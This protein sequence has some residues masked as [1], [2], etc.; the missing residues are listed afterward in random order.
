MR[1]AKLKQILP[2]LA[3]M[4]LALIPLR[5]LLW[6]DDWMTHDHQQYAVRLAAL[7]AAMDEGQFLGRWVSVLK[8]GWGYPLF[9]YYPPGF[10]LL[11]A[12]PY[13]AGLDLM[14]SIHLTLALLQMIG[15]AG[16]YG[17]GR[18]FMGRRAAMICA[19][20]WAFLPYQQVN[21]FVRGAMA[22]FA[23]LQ[24]LAAALFLQLRFI[25]KP[26]AANGAIAAAAISVMIITH[27][28]TA[29][30]GTAVLAAMGT[31]YSQRQQRRDWRKNLLLA[32]LPLIAGVGL[33][34]FYWLPALAE[35]HFVQTANMLGGYYD[36]RQH[37]LQW[38]Q[39]LNVFHWG[40]GASTAEPG[41]G[42]PRH[43][44]LAPLALVGLG[45]W[46]VAMR[47]RKAPAVLIAASL[48]ALCLLLLTLEASK[49]IWA[50]VPLMPYI[51]FP[52]RLLGEVGVLMALAGGAGAQMLFDAVA[53]H[54]RAWA[55]A[56][57]MGFVVLAPPWHWEPVKV[58]KPVLSGHPSAEMLRSRDWAV[59]G[60]DEFLPRDAAA[61]ASFPEIARKA[62]L[63]STGTARVVRSGGTARIHGG[64]SES[65]AI[66]LGEYW[67]PSVRVETSDASMSSRPDPMGLGAILFN[68]P[69][70]QF[71]V[72][73]RR[74]RTPMQRVGDV[75]SAVAAIALLAAIP[76]KR[77]LPLRPAGP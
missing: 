57:A 7:S 29:M 5:S 41:R 36:Y 51:Q 20:L 23:A 8:R 12:I 34:A 71:D 17:L 32:A 65:T 14:P 49:G 11:A 10:Y 42:M 46:L 55:L 33:S 4:L 58:V 67:F 75:I 18:L 73:V 70:G 47:G 15:A 50:F 66:L 61:C 76:W 39:W 31:W 54:K 2:V 25:R 59:T 64:A 72:T 52:W 56:A 21:L 69:A 62:L 26:S 1:P 38:T 40:F 53:E 37:F 9:H 30:A 13:R 16:M 24:W 6:V 77:I 74:M 43:L 68:V 35:R 27:A 60:V 45:W 28:I 63:Q 22:E 19:L 48:G 3:V 44:G